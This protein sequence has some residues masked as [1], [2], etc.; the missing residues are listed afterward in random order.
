MRTRFILACLL[1]SWPALASP[2]FTPLILGIHPYLEADKLQQRFAPLSKYLARNLL[3]PVQVRVALDYQDHLRAAGEDRL[4]MA[5]LGP[6]TYVRMIEEYGHKPIL[7]GLESGGAPCFHGHVV[8]REDSP[9]SSLEELRGRRFAFGDPHSTM[10]TLVPRDLLARAGI[11]PEHFASYRHLSGHENVALAV[12]SGTVDAGAVK[13]EVFEAY[14][15]RGLRAL[16]RTDCFPE[17]LFVGRANL[18]PG[19]IARLRE[20]LLGLRQAGAV[21]SVLVPIRKRATALIPVEDADYDP[22]RA[23]LSR[24]LESGH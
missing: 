19:W 7:A 17:Y 14:Q 12:L 5:F 11:R 16:A 20:L 8:V 15:E 23:I 24:A 13:A 22:L 4:D 1:I 18:D 9:V 3:H 6:L 21:A 10:G 2:P